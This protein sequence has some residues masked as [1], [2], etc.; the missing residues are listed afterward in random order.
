MGKPG[1]LD[2]HDAQIISD[3]VEGSTEVKALYGQ[4]AILKH[5]KSDLSIILETKEVVKHYREKVILLM[6]RP[7][8]LMSLSSLMVN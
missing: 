7:S 1:T 8:L 6:V 2:H 3:H 5:L 4:D